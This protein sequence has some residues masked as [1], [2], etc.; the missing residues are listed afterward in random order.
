VPLKDLLLTPGDLPD[1]FTV[2]I[3]EGTPPSEPDDGPT[4]ADEGCAS[5]A[6][7]DRFGREPLEAVYRLLVKDSSDEQVTHSVARHTDA[8][9]AAEALEGLRD[10]AAD[11]P[12]FESE[13]DGDVYRVRSKI[14]PGPGL[15][16]DSLH[17]VVTI[18]TVGATQAIG[19]AASVRRPQW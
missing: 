12:D 9:A 3:A 15:G 17:F 2:E 10:L 19:P 7:V 6:T 4:P 11:C 16:D 14:V 13:S 18:D 5:R 1:G 8:E